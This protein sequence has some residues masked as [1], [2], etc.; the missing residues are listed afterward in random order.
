MTLPDTRQIFL[1]K[2]P[3]KK[4]RI[5]TL[6]HTSPAPS[7]QPIHSQ[8]SG[9]EPRN[10]SD[11]PPSIQLNM[12][13]TTIA[14]FLLS[15]S[16]TTATPTSFNGNAKRQASLLCSGTAATPNCCAV[17]VLNLADLQCADRKLPTYPPIYLPNHHI[18]SSIH[19]SIPC[20]AMRD[21]WLSDSPQKLPHCQPTS[22]TSRKSAPISDKRLSA[23]LLIL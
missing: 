11:S 10:Q 23:A 8:A 3:I 22:R 21:R 15:A 7:F 16:L 12:H 6:F 18:H 4:S 5:P 19:S 14:A 1:R 17:N 20:R 13:F 9:Q 2:A